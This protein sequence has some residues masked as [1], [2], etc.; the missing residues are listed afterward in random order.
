MYTD[1]IVEEV[2]RIRRKHAEAFGNDLHAMCESLRKAQA[3]SGHRV[4]SR[5]P[6]P[7]RDVRP[8]AVAESREKYG[9]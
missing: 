6:R 2:H 7:V 9:S 3:A 4:V 1:P 8:L 5:P